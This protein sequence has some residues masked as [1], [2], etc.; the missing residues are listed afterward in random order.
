[1][2]ATSTETEIDDGP[3]LMI[4]KSPQDLRE[5]RAPQLP[6]KMKVLLISDPTTD[7]AAAALSVSV[8]KTIILL[9]TSI[10]RKERIVFRS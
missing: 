10:D 6:N 9:N 7:K 4:V 8:G 1:M 5:Y 2:M 3:T